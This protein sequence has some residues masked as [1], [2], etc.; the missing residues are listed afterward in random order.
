MYSKNITISFP[1]WF[2]IGISFCGIGTILICAYYIVWVFHTGQLN[3]HILRCSFCFGFI[4]VIFWF[5]LKIVFYSVIATERGLATSNIFKSSNI[6]LWD[7]IVEVRRPRFGIP[8][9]A[10]YVISENKKKLLLVRSMRNYKE[11]VE[12][13]KVKASNL[14]RCQ[15]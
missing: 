5:L 14:E 3:S 7:Q 15:L 2:V 6:F 9:D 13:I 1:K 12:L 8:Y 10:T 11:L 4:L